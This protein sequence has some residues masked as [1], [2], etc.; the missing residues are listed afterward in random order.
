MIRTIDYVELYMVEVIV[1]KVVPV[2]LFLLALLLNLVEELVQI[3]GMTNL[4]LMGNQIPRQ[5]LHQ[6]LSLY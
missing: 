4:M 5:M 2:L 1:E 3:L 6:I